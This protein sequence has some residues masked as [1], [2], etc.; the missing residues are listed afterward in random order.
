M[1]YLRINL[2]SEGDVLLYEKDVDVR[3]V[4]DPLVRAVVSRLVTDGTVYEGE[5]Y[6]ALVIPRYGDKLKLSPIVA[7]DRE[8][9]AEQHQ[10]IELSYEDPIDPDR[11]IRYFT[12]EIRIRDRGIIIRRDFQTNVVA[13]HYVAFGVSQALL[14]LGELQRGDYYLTEFFAHDDDRADF[15]REFMPALQKRVASLVT[16]M[17]E[18]R[19]SEPV[20]PLCDPARYGEVE[21]VG[22]P[23]PASI[24]IYVRREAMK[25]LREEGLLSIEAERGGMLVGE[26][27][28]NA[29]GGRRIVEVSD[30]TVSE[31][32][33]A[34]VAELRYTFES[35][36]AHR[37]L[38]REK[39]PGKRVVGWYH[40]HLLTLPVV[41]RQDHHDMGETALFFSRDD[42]FTHRQFFRDEWYVAMVLDQKGECIFFQWRGGEIVAVDGY[43][44]FEDV[45]VAAKEGT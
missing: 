2:R 24:G 18:G 3:H 20:F 35:W 32:T 34:S 22:A 29:R 27:Y 30:L 8:K 15:D 13:E 39:F 19:P 44:I 21:V 41:R 40:T 5:R 16:F 43:H 4:M 1:K 11:V 17:D 31:H 25:R 6:Y 14:R 26:V 9:T 37:A 38:M 36:Q 28:E 42:V 12:L 23:T 7:F 33:R 45:G 10:W